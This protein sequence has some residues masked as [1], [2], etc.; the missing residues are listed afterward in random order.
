MVTPDRPRRSDPLVLTP[1]LLVAAY[2]QGMFPMAEARN[3]DEVHWYSPQHRAVLPL[4]AFRCPRSVRQAIQRN[5]FEIR[6]DTCFSQVIRSCALPR[7]GHLETWI[8][9]QI[10]EA[11]IQLHRRGLAHCV[12]A[13]HEQ[14]LVG[15]LYGVALGGAFF[16]ES[17]FH[18]PELGGS[19]ASKVCLAYLV[20][21]LKQRGFVLLDTQISSEHMAQFGVVEIPR[22]QYLGRLEAALEVEARF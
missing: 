13:W 3:S 12:E 4:D 14:R 11:Y 6:H 19:N 17:M 18:R 5:Q 21:H 20:E 9:D 22:E 1:K 15:G 7:P 10:I 2:S 16:G 8:N